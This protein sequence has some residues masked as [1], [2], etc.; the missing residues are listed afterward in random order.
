MNDK[1]KINLRIAET[2]YPLLVSPHEEQM[3][4]EAAKRVNVRI[5]TYRTHFSK[6]K[7]EEIIAMVAYEFSR[8][9]LKLRE[10]ND[11]VPYKEKIEELT[12]LLED[13]FKNG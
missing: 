10:V 7:P 12:S 11:T 2:Y 4:R 9:I 6:Q 5:N 8:E 3:A 13:Y 1:I